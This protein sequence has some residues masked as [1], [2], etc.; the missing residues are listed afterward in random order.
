[1]LR[2]FVIA[3]T[4]CV[5]CV[6]GAETPRTFALGEETLIAIQDAPSTMA[7]R[8]F[9]ALSDADFVAL[10][11]GAAAPS[12]INVFV[13]RRGERD[14]LVDA[15]NGGTRGAMLAT[16]KSVGIQP[17]AIEDILLTHMHGDHIGG[18]IDDSGTAV[19]PKATLHVSI[20][21]R[22]YWLKQP[23]RNGDQARK[24]FAAYAGRIKTFAFDENPLP[25]IT[26]LDASGHT[27]GHTAYETDNLLIVGDLLHAASV[28][29]P[30]PDMSSAYD[31]DPAKAAET[32]LRLY[33]RAA[34]SGKPMA[35]MHLPYPG[36]GR[37]VKEAS[38]FRYVPTP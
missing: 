29:I 31:V 19:F 12:S 33:E 32:R 38:V 1:M 35:G 3:A 2:R 28:Q 10:V 13:L 23:G 24:V 15:G 25:G 16:L 30:R 11:G 4:L 37:I 36:L 34:A 26:A 14:I 6:V 27:P 9:P 17:D 18:L 8:L 20:P 22:D 5:A 21:E 7:R